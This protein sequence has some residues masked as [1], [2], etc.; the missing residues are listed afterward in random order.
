MIDLRFQPMKDRVKSSPGWTT[1]NG[2]KRFR[3]APFKK[4]VGA[5]YDDLERELRLLSATDVVIE[6]GHDRTSIRNDGW[7]RSSATASHSDIRL[8]FK[9]KHGNLRYE[10]NAFGDWQANLRAIGL[11]L[12]RQRLAIEEWG[13][14]TGGEA[15]RGFA[16]LPGSVNGIAVGEW[17]TVEDAAA[18]LIQVAEDPTAEPW[19]VIDGPLGEGQSVFRDAARK[20]HPDAGGTNDLMS[21]VNR[22]RD[23]ITKHKKP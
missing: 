5:G 1:R 19:M 15:Y 2:Q 3:C 13:I 4:S 22:A 21:K 16:A 7:P 17:G 20:A 12:Q 23:F 9:C 14:G 8:F 11:W 18:F 6:S 10:C